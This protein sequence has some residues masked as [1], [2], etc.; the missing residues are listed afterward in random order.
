MI[1]VEANIFEFILKISQQPYV[2]ISYFATD[3]TSMYWIL[4]NNNIGQY[5]SYC[6]NEL[7]HFT[8]KTWKYVLYMSLHSKTVSSIRDEQ[9]QINSKLISTLVT[10][11]YLQIWMIFT[12]SMS[13]SRWILILLFT[14][15]QH[16]LAIKP[17]VG[18]RHVCKPDVMYF[19][20]TLMF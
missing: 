12:C 8:S 2:T 4:L 3:T 11:Y 9:F 7:L 15:F 6:S 5:S 13:I 16:W 10:K 20:N 14:N 19:W 17:C 18:D 1:F